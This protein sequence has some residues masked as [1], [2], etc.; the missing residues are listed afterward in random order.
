MQVGACVD[1]LAVLEVHRRAAGSIGEDVPSQESCVESGA[2]APGDEGHAPAWLRRA[3]EAYRRG[4]AKVKESKEV[5]AATKATVWGT[6]VDGVA[7]AV[8][9]PAKK[10][11]ELV[12]ITVDVLH[13]SC[14]DYSILSR[15]VGSWT[16]VLMHARAAFAILERTFVLVA[17]LAKR[18]FESARLPARVWDKLALW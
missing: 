17:D 9:T 14:V 1:D 7:G 6:E 4:G 2:P 13:L 12:R 11:V 16:P 15:L 3:E 5:D 10:V 8:A 18:P